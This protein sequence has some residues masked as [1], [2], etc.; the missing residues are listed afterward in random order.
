M[1]EVESHSPDIGSRR[2]DRRK[3]GRRGRRRGVRIRAGS[4]KQARL[5]AGLSLGQVAQGDISRTAIYFV[6][7]GKAK[8]SMETLRLIADRTGRPLDFF[9]TELMTAPVQAAQIAELERLMATGDNVGAAARSEHLLGQ[10]LDADSQARV[11]LLAALA[12]LR[13]GQPVSGR[14]Y[15][16][17]ARNHFEHSGD[18]LMTAEALG[19][20]AQGAYLM[21]D[22]MALP[23]AQD[24]L[25]TLRSVKSY[26]QT[27]ES[28]LLMILASIH[29]LNQN[30]QEAI[31]IY[32]QAIAAGD[33]VHDLHS[34]SLMYSGLSA[35]YNESGQINEA[36]RYAQKALTIHETLNDRMSLARSLN[37]LGVMLMRI[38]ETISARHHIERSLQIF[39]EEQVESRKGDVIL[40][41]S[42]L[43]FMQ[44]NLDAAQKLA[45]E[46]LEV[47]SRLGEVAIQSE[48]HTWL[49]RI[50]AQ[51][52]RHDDADTEFAAAISV[53]ES[54]GP[55]S[56]LTQAF[57]V[58]AEVLEA[59]GDLAGANRQ[60]KQALGASR[61][62]AA[63]SR[64]AIA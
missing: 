62:R 9:L 40:S 54:F 21:H 43:E 13:L 30:W 29:V 8:P 3:T 32:Q 42:E 20:E 26:P 52:G 55:G 35:A 2:S 27:I 33:V 49:G 45:N 63:E 7:T 4:V 22:P 61:P 64:I 28:R 16:S 14:R 57:E 53:A 59:R 31:D 19:T 41:L 24:A 36:T 38:N 58:Y 60:L 17:A 48:A 39:Y 51:Q 25:E 1:P 12:Y 37:N 6:E 18:R 23:M 34:L 11:K 10:R 56:R 47:S 44:G 15:A 50:A 5:E 46:A